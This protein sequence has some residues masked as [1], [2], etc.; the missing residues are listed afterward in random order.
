MDFRKRAEELVSKMSLA[1]KMSQMKFDSPPIERLGIPGYNWWNEGLHES[2][3]PA[4]RPAS[5]R[6]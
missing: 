3:A 5:L 4:R 6:Q 2:P 1:E